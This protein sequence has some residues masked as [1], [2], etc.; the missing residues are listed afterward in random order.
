MLLGTFFSGVR[1]REHCSRGVLE[2]NRMPDADG[3]AYA[4]FAI[5]GRHQKLARMARRIS[6]S[7]SLNGDPNF[8]RKRRPRRTVPLLNQ[9]RRPSRAGTGARH[10][11]KYNLICVHGKRR[12]PQAARF[13]YSFWY[14]KKA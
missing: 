13:E 2:L 3:C 11:P 1:L 8:R 7:A 5:S 9:R 4:L 12:C 10:R 14:S 6:L